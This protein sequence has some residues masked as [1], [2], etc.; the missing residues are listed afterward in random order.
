MW[1]FYAK[2]FRFPK[3][4]VTPEPERQ[5]QNRF[6]V[7]FL[8]SLKPTGQKRTPKCFDIIFK[9]IRRQKIKQGTGS[10]HIPNEQGLDRV[11]SHRKAMLIH[12]LLILEI[13]SQTIYGCLLIISNPKIRCHPRSIPIWVR[14]SHKVFLF[15]SAASSLPIRDV[16]LHPD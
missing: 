10:S 11:P 15:P 5:Y 9:V 7:V 6:S 2:H 14:L 3:P 1:L 4:A 8:C 16:N 12:S 13:L